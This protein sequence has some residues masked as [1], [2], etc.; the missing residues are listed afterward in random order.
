MRFLHRR[1][2]LVVG[3]LLAMTTRALVVVVVAFLVLVRILVAVLIRV[4]MATSRA[5]VIVT[6]LVVPVDVVMTASG[7]IVT[8]SRLA[9]DAWLALQDRLIGGGAG[10]SGYILG[11][12]SRVGRIG[13]VAP[14]FLGRWQV[15]AYR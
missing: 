15:S 4:L 8:A 3:F 10:A 11:T 2:F 6:V 12:R 7:A 9:I 13:I 5:V 14:E 1:I